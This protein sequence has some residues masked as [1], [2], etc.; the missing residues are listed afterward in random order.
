MS[1]MPAQRCED[2]THVYDERSPDDGEPSYRCGYRVPFWVPVPIY[3]YRSWVR[4]DDGA[5]CSAFERNVNEGPH[6]WRSDNQS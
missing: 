3:D 5:R 6:R 4:P 2:C 1:N